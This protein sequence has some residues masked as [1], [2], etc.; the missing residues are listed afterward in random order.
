MRA[1]NHV[2][3]GE[4]DSEGHK[5]RTKNNGFFLIRAAAWGDQGWQLQVF[6]SVCR[7]Q[8]HMYYA[9]STLFT[10][11]WYIYI[12]MVVAST[13]AWRPTSNKDGCVS[14]RSASRSLP[15]YLELLCVALHNI[16]QCVFALCFP[17]MPTRWLDI[18][19]SMYV[20]SHRQSVT[21]SAI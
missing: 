21:A 13:L 17:K 7:I 4:S 8:A 10:P 18:L 12:A 2:H 20:I 9:R 1:W 3:A 16:L 11:P 19:K 14:S 6:V 15:P 5:K